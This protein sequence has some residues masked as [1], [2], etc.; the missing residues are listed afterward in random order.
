MFVLFIN[1]EE[2]RRPPVDPLIRRSRTP[3]HGPDDPI[4]R[5]FRSAIR[6]ENRLKT[7]L[8]Q[9][10]SPAVMDGSERPSPGGDLPP[11][12]L[13]NRRIKYAAHQLVQEGP[14]N[15]PGLGQHQ[16]GVPDFIRARSVER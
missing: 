3:A 12:L 16:G 13:R 1:F 14:Q 7:K 15:P 5:P 10:Q 8:N 11:S 9:A 4:F 6:A 2:K